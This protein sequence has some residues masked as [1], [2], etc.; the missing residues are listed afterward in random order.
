MGFFNKAYCGA[1]F[2]LINS[3][4]T[5]STDFADWQ[6]YGSIDIYQISL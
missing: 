4:I 5:V 3:N 2:N 1:Q 6:I